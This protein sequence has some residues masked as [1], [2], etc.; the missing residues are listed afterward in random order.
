MGVLGKVTVH[1]DQI[2]GGHQ[3]IGVGYLAP[4]D[5]EQGS[6]TKGIGLLGDLYF[7]FDPEYLLYQGIL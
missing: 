5:L 7:G 3:F 6:G 2:T 4:I 1:V